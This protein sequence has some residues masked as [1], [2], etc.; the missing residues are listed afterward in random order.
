MDYLTIYS[1]LFRSMHV[2]KTRLHRPVS[3]CVKV[4][5]S[6][7][8]IRTITHKK[9]DKDI[10]WEDSIARAQLFEYLV[11]RTCMMYYAY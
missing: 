9:T 6:L 1:S 3:S 8:F 4:S 11:S 2:I 5:Q 7:R 10:E